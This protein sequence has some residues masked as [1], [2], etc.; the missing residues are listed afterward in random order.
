MKKLL[1]K[2]VFYSFLFILSLEA[3]VRTF[4]LSKD[5]P[6][7]YL[8]EY[9]VEKWKPNQQG[10]SV[11]GNRRQNFSEFNINASGFNSYREYNPSVDKK[12][13]A[14][15]GDSF[16]EGFHQDYFNSIGKKIENQLHS[17]EVYEYAYAGYDMADQLHLIHQYKKQF[18]K[19]DHV[20]ISLT[21]DSDLTRGKYNVIQDRLALETSYNRLFKK[22]K[23]LVYAKKIGVFDPIKKLIY[24]IKNFNHNKAAE[25]LEKTIPVSNANSK[26]HT[27][28]LDNFKNLVSLYGYDKKRFVLLLDESKTNPGFIHFLTKNGFAYIDYSQNFKASKKTTH[29]IYDQ[30]WNNHGRNLIANLIAKYIQERLD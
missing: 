18:D 20:I 11:T 16:I 8:D 24:R 10:F 5:Y 15:V 1:F 27:T 3:L 21:Y 13:I 22:S 25:T 29:L 28:Y 7:R 19:I 14:I 4:H 12:E 6:I 26:K 30:H 17:I 9:N 2:S 23:L